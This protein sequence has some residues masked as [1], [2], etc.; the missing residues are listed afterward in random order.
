VGLRVALGGGGGLSYG[1]RV[2]RGKL[3]FGMC[4]GCV[5]RCTVLTG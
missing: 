4:L 2:D 5:C 1:G 3:V